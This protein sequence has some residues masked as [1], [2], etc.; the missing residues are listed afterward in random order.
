MV[1]FVVMWFGNGCLLVSFGLLASWVSLVSL[2][3]SS[4]V[5][6]SGGLEGVFGRLRGLCVEFFFGGKGW[7][8]FWMC[9]G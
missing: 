4:V 7:V 8:C 1:T 5:V 6:K 2:G 3:L 9:W